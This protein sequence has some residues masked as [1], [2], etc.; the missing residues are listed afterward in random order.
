MSVPGAVDPILSVPSETRR[1]LPRAALRGLRGLIER[2]APSR[3]TVPAAVIPGSESIHLGGGE[4]V[5]CPG[6]ERVPIAAPERG[7]G[8]GSP[9]LAL[10]PAKVSGLR[11]V[12]IVPGQR[13]VIDRRGAVVAESI[14]SDMLDHLDHDALRRARAVPNGDAVTIDGVAAIFRSPW[15]APYHTLIDHLPRAALLAQPAMVRFG[16]VSLLHDGELSDFETLLLKRLLPSRVQL[17]QV[18][19]SDVVD[20]QTV[21]VP[22]YV[23]RPGAGAIPSWYR[24][25]VDRQATALAHQ[26]DP[27]AALPRRFFIELSDSRRIHNSDEFR[28]L[29]EVHGVASVDL[30]Q[31]SAIEVIQLFRDASLVLGA[32]GSALANAIFSRSARILEILPGQRVLPAFYYLAMSKGLE[33]DYVAAPL[34]SGS[35]A[36]VDLEADLTVDIAALAELLTV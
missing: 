26:V 5:M 8:V 31:L 28:A 19:P 30:S 4:I 1:S 23:T 21:L 11:R 15:R 14:T 33:Y 2:R 10:P 17:V 12:R 9:S 34:S 29:L 24:R 25:W 16:E 35:G 36:A 22:G 20:A 32:T 13:V 7:H 18:D 3:S 27:D 6:I